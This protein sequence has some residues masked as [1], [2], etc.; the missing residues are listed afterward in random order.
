MSSSTGAIPAL[1]A[2]SRPSSS[3]SG[4][5]S[6]SG[7]S[8]PTTR[9]GPSARAQSAAQTVLSTPPESPTTTP[10]FRIPWTTVEAMAAVISE[11]TCSASMRSRS[12]ETLGAKGTYWAP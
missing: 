9:S 12:G 6:R 5:D 2:A 11:T 7:M 8:N 1:S 3:E 4:D 10:R